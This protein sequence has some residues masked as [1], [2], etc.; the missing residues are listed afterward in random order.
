MSKRAN[1]KS[2]AIQRKSNFLTLETAQRVGEIEKE[3]S[4]IFDAL[5]GKY[6]PKFTADPCPDTN[7]VINLLSNLEYEIRAKTDGRPQPLDFEGTHG[8]SAD[9]IEKVSEST[10]EYMLERNSE[11]REWARCFEPGYNEVA[12]LGTIEMSIPKLVEVRE[13]ID[14][15]IAWHKANPKRKAN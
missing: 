8:H 2:S 11:L 6:N 1:A 14:E 9:T 15:V 4:E 12:S 5:K 3:L 13:W 7:D 10:K